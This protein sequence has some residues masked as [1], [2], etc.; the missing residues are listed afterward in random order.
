MVR[1][2]TSFVCQQ[3]G[4]EFSKWMGKCPSCGEWNSI[5]ETTRF[6]RDGRRAKGNKSSSVKPV[7]LGSIKADFKKRTQTKIPELDRA[8]GGGIVEGQVV[9]IAGEPGVGKSTLLLELASK[10]RNTL[11]VSGE[12]S[13]SQV[14][15]R[16]ERLGLGGKTI[17]FVEATDIDVVI[18]SAE[19][20]GENVS[21]S[22]KAVLIVDSIQTMA[23]Q[24]L[25][26]MSG[27]VGQV[28][29]C[30]S[31]LVKFAKTTG[32]AVF[33]AGHVTKQ[34]SVAG[35]SVLMHIVDTVL[36]FEGDATTSLRLLRAHKNRFGPTDEVGVFSMG[37]SG[38]V[39]ETSPEKLFLSKSGKSQ[40]GSVV[41]ATLQGTRVILT[42]VQALVVPTKTAFPRRIVQGI[43]SNK[44]ELLLAVLIKRADLPLYNFDCYLNISGGISVKEPSVDLAVCMAVASSYFDKSLAGGTCA[45]GEIGLLGDIRKVSM[46]EKRVREA[47]KL[48][49][50]NIISSETEKYIG[51]VIKNNLK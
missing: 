8:L 28:R 32:T 29:E 9:L 35:P 42:E 15:I 12:E 13:L 43:S 31:R 20:L 3:C 50:K 39:S 7:V 4:N 48:G 21:K 45:L 36:W 10:I 2:N 27:S 41:T 38:L 1:T 17:K 49:Y 22:G 6:N 37:D 26:G 33:L 24:D 40:P 18:D 16:A 30:A 5:V 47:K 23:T 19:K 51:G 46:Q 11:Y 34:G 25:S 44:F 14:S